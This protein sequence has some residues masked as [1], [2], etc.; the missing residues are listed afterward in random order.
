MSGSASASYSS[1]SAS[2]SA[3]GAAGAEATAELLAA[4]DAGT[5]SSEMAHGCKDRHASLRQGLAYAMSTGRVA[6][7]L[8]LA[9]D[10]SVR[11]REG[12]E[13]APPEEVLETAS[14]KDWASV[15]YQVAMA[16]DADNDDLDDLIDAQDKKACEALRKAAGEFL[17]QMPR[18][19]RI[20]SARLGKAPPVVQVE[21]PRWMLPRPRKDEVF[22]TRDGAK[23]PDGMYRVVH[24]PL[25]D[26][27]REA[28]LRRRY[29]DWEWRDC[30]A[31]LL[32]CTGETLLCKAAKARQWEI[33]EFILEKA[34][35]PEVK[36]AAQLRD[37]FSVVWGGVERTSFLQSHAELETLCASLK[38][39]KL[40]CSWRSWPLEVPS[41]ARLRSPKLEVL[42]DALELGPLSIQ[43]LRLVGGV[44]LVFALPQN[45]EVTR[46]WLADLRA[47]EEESFA[48]PLLH[49]VAEGGPRS[50]VARLLG[51]LVDAEARDRRGLTALAA[52][53]VA[54]RAEAVE[55]LLDGGCLADGPS[56]GLATAA[57]QR[58]SR[59][60][61]AEAPQW[62]A[63]FERLRERRRR[64]PAASLEDYF[65]RQAAGELVHGTEPRLYELR[66]GELRVRSGGVRVSTR[67]LALDGVA[68]AGAAG[69]DVCFVSLEHGVYT[70][71]VESGVLDLS[72]WKLYNEQQLLR[73]K[74]QMAMPV[75]ALRGRLRAG[76]GDTLAMGSA[77]GGP[78]AA[79]LPLIARAPPLGGL[80][81]ESVT[82]CCQA[83]IGKVSVVVDGVRLGDTLAPGPT[84][85]VG[86]E[87]KL[88]VP[89]RELDVV[90]EM[91]G[92][93]V[94]QERVTGGPDAQL[95][96]EVG[97]AVYLYVL[98]VDEEG[99][100]DFVFVCG[101]RGDMPE[102][103]RPFVGSVTW[104]SGSA[105]VSNH[106]PAVMEATSEGSCLTCLQSMRLAPTLPAG[107]R[108]EMVEW[109]DTST[110]EQ[111]A[112]QY[113]RCL[114]NPVRVG[115]IESVE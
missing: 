35:D 112:C 55:A 83:S 92:R 96:F 68:E 100:L 109:E 113:Q 105:K 67:V 34:G 91:S 64:P 51:A 71:A 84:E 99:K 59:D 39:D 53:A 60:G 90:A 11:L 30:V 61:S 40:R 93:R 89:A 29:F 23:V 81:A 58:L 31:N 115:K 94:A 97:L 98:P 6:A 78:Y 107:K 28:L 108:F 21:Q 22:L 37:E 74:V 42:Q 114:I 76:P 62:A 69:I 88:L 82:K 63:L 45:D 38:G 44:K 2:A 86:D 5:L 75:A 65:R 52:A 87:L 49:H 25:G 16:A 72:R 50:L 104:D 48:R 95:C 102:E 103:A 7:I 4:I 3:S 32:R 1:V 110:E 41:G 56:G 33:V 9:Y 15:A 77:G 43:A 46:Q 24:Y 13:M 66:D 20:K 12:D 111:K 73:A 26:D 36:L 27:L 14:R 19:L 85:T 10:C 80:R 47:V 79:S 101:H 57:A 17:A 18:D 106:E 70:G 8:T 54:G